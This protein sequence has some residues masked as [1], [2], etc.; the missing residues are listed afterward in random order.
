MAV[1]LQENPASGGPGIE[2]HW[3]VVSYAPVRTL[4]ANPGA[5]AG[6]RNSIIMQ[7]CPNGCLARIFGVEWT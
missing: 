1:L 2:P 6:G 3:T 5:S 4:P 7:V